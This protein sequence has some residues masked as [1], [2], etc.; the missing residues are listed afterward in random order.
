[1]TKMT[2]DMMMTKMAIM[3]NQKEKREKEKNQIE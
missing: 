3:T 2:T 1:M